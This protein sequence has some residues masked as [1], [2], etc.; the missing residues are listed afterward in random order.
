[1]SIPQ[2]NVNLLT[3]DKISTLEI[4]PAPEGYTDQSIELKLVAE[5]IKFTTDLDIKG[6]N[7]PIL[8]DPDFKDTPVITLKNVDV[9]A[10]IDL[11]VFKMSNDVWNEFQLGQIISMPC[12]SQVVS[13]VT[14]PHFENTIGDLEIL[15]SDNWPSWLT[16]HADN[17]K[18]KIEQML[19]TQFEQIFNDS[20][21]A[22]LEKERTK[23]CNSLPYPGGVEPYFA[24]TGLL[25]TLLLELITTG[26]AFQN[27]DGSWPADSFQFSINDLMNALLGLGADSTYT[28]TN[29]ASLIGDGDF[30]YNVT[31]AELGIVGLDQFKNLDLRTVTAQE[32]FVSLGLDNIGLN[33][34]VLIDVMYPNSYFENPSVGMSSISELHKNL[35]DIQQGNPPD[36]QTPG[37]YKSADGNYTIIQNLTLGFGVADAASSQDLGLYVSDQQVAGLYVQSITDNTV[38]ALE[39]LQ[40]MTVSDLTLSSGDATG[41]FY[42]SSPKSQYADC[43]LDALQALNQTWSTQ[44]S[45]DQ[46]N[47]FLQQG[48]TFISTPQDDAKYQNGTPFSTDLT[49]FLNQQFIPGAHDS[50][51]GIESQTPTK[52]IGAWEDGS[53]IFK[54]IAIAFF[55]LF[56]LC[57]LGLPLLYGWWNE[58][59]D[60]EEDVQSEKTEEFEDVYCAQMADSSSSRVGYVSPESSVA[61]GLNLEPIVE[62]PSHDTAT[63]ASRATTLST[64]VPGTSTEALQALHHADRTTRNTLS[65]MPAVE[66]LYPS[67]AFHRGTPMWSRWCVPLYIIGTTFLFMSATC[68]Y[69]SKVYANVEI[70]G[71]TFQVLVDEFTLANSISRSW[72]ANTYVLAILIALSAV[73]WPYLRLIFLFALWYTPPRVIRSRARGRCL[74]MIDFLGK[75]CICNVF[76]IDQMIIGFQV[77]VNNTDTWKNIA[78]LPKDFL[79]VDMWVYPEYGVIAYVIG[80]ILTQILQQFLLHS[81]RHCAA[82]DHLP[83]DE[84]SAAQ[85]FGHDRRSAAMATVKKDPLTLATRASTSCDLEEPKY[86]LMNHKFVS[87]KGHV[88][89]TKFGAFVSFFILTCAVACLVV[90]SLVTIIRYDFQGLATIVMGDQVTRNYSFWDMANILIPTY[91][92]ET[93]SMRFIWFIF[94]FYGFIMPLVYLLAIIALWILPLSLWGQRAVHIACESFQSWQ[95]LEVFLAAAII[96]GLSLGMFSDMLV[97]IPCDGLNKVIVTFNDWLQLDNPTCFASVATLQG[98]IALLIFSAVFILFLGQLTLG[99][100]RL[101][102]QDRTFHPEEKEDDEPPKKLGKGGRKFFRFLRKGLI[103]CRFIRIVEHDKNETEMSDRSVAKDRLVEH[104]DAVHRHTPRHM[105]V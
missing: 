27:S 70:S 56:G 20:I 104:G 83:S 77:H 31:L 17:I 74:E 61:D 82:L 30:F 63:T 10:V 29:V 1:M 5:E 86:A 11:E 97:E 84:R 44:A 9:D 55:V 45:K 78:F 105:S 103:A 47:S 73:V 4:N 12:V 81:H 28:L 68:G 65:F 60:L 13:N 6:Q 98:A 32:L 57:F 19:T 54:Y 50:C 39:P 93:A 26:F 16:I 7:I 37:V 35:D 51:Q 76:V 96:S 100:S 80:C 2:G 53:T 38:C 41:S 92:E 46:I 49:K 88:E 15:I 72:D 43:P 40:N 75:W 67:L 66:K 69:A 89:V 62:E 34:N 58:E 94:I 85:T 42:C 36:D 18:A 79:T 90:G 64:T 91:F 22:Y 21:P 99:L 25:G 48:L 52:Y 102:L 8:G 24:F 33:G 95:A 71:L 101:A 3:L 23:T 87:E 59:E 14:S